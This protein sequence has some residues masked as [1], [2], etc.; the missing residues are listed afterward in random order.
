MSK[1]Y[2]NP[3]HYENIAKAIREKNGTEETYKPSEMADAIRAIETDPVVEDLVVEKNGVYTPPA[4]VD[5]FSRVV[6]QV[7]GG[8][9]GGNADIH[10]YAPKI[11]LGDVVVNYHTDCELKMPF[12]EHQFILSDNIR[13]IEATGIL[14]VKAQ[15]GEN[16]PLGGLVSFLG[17][18]D[19]FRFSNGLCATVERTIEPLGIND[20]YQSTEPE[21]LRRDVRSRMTVVRNNSKMDTG[22]DT[23]SLSQP[24]PRVGFGRS[25]IASLSVNGDSYISGGELTIEINKRDAASVYVWKEEGEADG[26]HFIKIRWKGCSH[27]NQAV[28]QEWEAVFLCN[29]DVILRL[30]E[31]GG[32]SGTYSFN[33]KA[34]TITTEEPL[35]FYRQDY[36]G[37]TWDVSPGEYSMEKHH[38]EADTLFKSTTLAESGKT[39]EGAYKVVDNV[40]HDDDTV[41]V[42]LLPF[43]WH[44]WKSAYVSGNSW[45]GI[46]GNTEDIKLH[47]NDAKLYDLSLNYFTLTDLDDLKALQIVWGGAASYNGARDRWWTLWLFENG[48]AMIYVSTIGSV[49]STSSFFGQPF[50]ATNDMFVSFYYDL[51]KQN[52]TI[53]NEI[54]DITHHIDA[55]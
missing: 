24:F 45:I 10:W 31:R 16:L 53:L 8:S 49:S 44:G 47:R 34:Y 38:P 9:S 36:Y 50:G 29:G 2:T 1:I 5:G 22:S 3:I 40:G 52:Y 6:V 41:T 28:D 27:Y 14:D 20:I 13:S 26:V 51:Q 30:I 32:Y 42:S 46:S 54:Y 35:C 17:L 43:A 7:E 55:E 37:T 19:A 39:L 18:T 23:I 11:C 15:L 25:D 21:D 33:G 4:E 48:D 12:D